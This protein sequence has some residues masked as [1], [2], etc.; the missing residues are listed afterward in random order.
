MA[1][2]LGERMTDSARELG[3]HASEQFE[4][5]SSQV[6]DA[7]DDVTGKGQDVRDDVAD[8]LA[9]GAREV[10]RYAVAAKSDRAAEIPLTPNVGGRRNS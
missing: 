6:G 4:Q 2:E 8:A 1:S 3:R 10:E 5:A 9:R 7:V